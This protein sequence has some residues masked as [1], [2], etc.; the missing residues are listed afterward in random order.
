MNGSL[1][2]VRSRS[3][4]RPYRCGDLRAE[5]WRL[6]LADRAARV[7]QSARG[8]T[9]RQRLSKLKV[10]L[11]LAF[12]LAAAMPSPTIAAEAVAPI[13]GGLQRDGLPSALR[14]RVLFSELGCTSCHADERADP[15]EGKQAPDVRSIGSRLQPDYVRRFIADPHGVK[16]GTTMP[17]LLGREPT[18]TAA[19]DADDERSE[20]S[21]RAS[22]SEALT[23]YLYSLSSHAFSLQPP[24]RVAAIE[25]RRLFHEIGCVACHSPRDAAGRDLLGASSVPLG[26]LHE[27]YSVR[28]LIQFLE[29]PH[30]VR[31]SGRMPRFR[32]SPNES[33][34]LANYLVQETRVPGALQYT[35]FLG[36]MEEGPE[37]LPGKEHRAGLADGFDLQAFAEY[38]EDF[39]VRF[40]G[41]LRVDT[42]G[43]YTFLLEANHFA[44][45]SLAGE[46]VIKLTKEGGAQ[47]TVELS[48]GLHPIAVLYLHVRGNPHLDLGWSGPGLA[49]GPIP[50]ARLT[51][52]SEAAEP[53]V[54]LQVDPSK[55]AIGRRLFDEYRCGH[56]H[57]V[58]SASSKADSLPTL[59]KLRPD[60]GCLSEGNSE[61]DGA[62]P[63]FSLD[64]RQAGDLRAALADLGRTLEAEEQ[65]SLTLTGLNCIACH[66]RGE[67]GGVPQSRTGYFVSA[68][69]NLAE[70]GRLPPPLTGA[71]A[72][73][74][75]DWLA[76]TVAKG[77]ALRPYMSLRMPEFG[78]A[79]VGS[80]AQLLGEVDRLPEITFPSLPSDKKEARAVRDVGRKLVGTDG[81]SCIVCHT[82]AGS[83]SSTMAAIDLVDTTTQRL[84]KDWFYHYMLDPARFRASTIMPQF[85]PEGRSILPDVAGGDATVQ[86]HAMWEYLAEGRNTG[87]PRGLSRQSME[88]KVSDEAVILRRSAQQSSK[89][90]ISIGYPLRL[91][92][93]FDAESVALQQIWRGDFIDAGGVWGGQGSG[94]VRPMSRERVVLG[95]GAPFAVLTAAD[96]PWPTA[97]SRKL[98]IRFKGYVLDAQ[99]RPTFRYRVG[100]IDVLDTLLDVA[101]PGEHEKGAD[102]NAAFFRRRV[103]L[104]GTPTGTLYFRPVQH[105]DIETLAGGGVRVGGLVS[106]QVTAANDEGAL[107]EAV[108]LTRRPAAK[109]Y[110]VVL[111]VPL[112]RGYAEWGIEYH[113]LEKAE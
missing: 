9:A 100:S 8:V 21:R 18:G 56:C 93:I 75:P 27:K 34:R 17:D 65:V 51:S 58:D 62:W 40:V 20:T 67:L 68:D 24:D 31:P 42:P 106:V 30:A 4:C 98:G 15:I 13:V 52:E 19:D 103:V 96:E 44:D 5:R 12:G 66:A 82:F 97:T 105:E 86:L 102:H 41:H 104:R 25:G 95:K 48:T 7:Q 39:A 112:E 79:N 47:A 80:L 74:Q 50:A 23:H 2:R 29:A 84:R 53:F 78:Y 38:R 71:G 45:L 22:A 26:R 43:R 69:E 10:T 3:N 6:G 35:L 113:W 11:T 88:I 59:A 91:N 99:R 1:S 70:P 83:G 77:Q 94:A 64:G 55:A 49:K 46:S 60:R 61:V 111:R 108:T 57:A 63:R 73:F 14:G 81:M 72:K 92:A 101:E 89:R 32:L 85:F 54:P 109:G 16:P 87:R 28:S 37:G 33:Y 107:A 110:E 90:A 76:K 36:D